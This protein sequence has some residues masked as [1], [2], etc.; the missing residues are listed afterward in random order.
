MARVGPRFRDIPQFTRTASYQ[1]DISWSY[2]L[3]ALRGYTERDGLDLD[4]DFQ[5]AHVW[6]EQKQVRYVEFILR[7]GASG[8]DIY[9][10]C[11]RWDRGGVKDF[12]LVDGKQRLQ[13]V[14]K[15]LRSELVIFGKYRFSDYTDSLR[16]TQAGFKWHVN[17]LDTRAEVL[18]WYLDLNSGGV[19]H[20]NEELERVRG[21]LAEEM[22]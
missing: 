1:V 21:L 18:Q 19:V 10:N 20:T 9:T 7:G 17:D 15:F 11:P 13:A 4:P 5:R 12:V 14:T 6:D 8:K 22:K 16:I 3:E 2:L